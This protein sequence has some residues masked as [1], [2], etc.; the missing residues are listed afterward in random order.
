MHSPTFTNTRGP[1]TSEFSFSFIFFHFLSF[2]LSSLGAQN[3]FFWGFNFVTI[4]LDSSYVKNQLLGPSRVVPLWALFSFFSY[5]VFLPFFCL[6]FLLFFYFFS[7][8]V[9]FFIFDFLMFFI[10]FFSFF[11]K[12]KF[13]LLFFLVFLSNI[14]YCWRQYQSLTVSSVVGAPWRCGVLTT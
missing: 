1:N 5:F 9:H 4:S 11:P 7:F 8:F 14:F 12:K 10:F 3:L 6:F 2:F 13:L